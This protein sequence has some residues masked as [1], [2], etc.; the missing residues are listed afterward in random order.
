[1][2][3]ETRWD[4]FIEV[5]ALELALETRYLGKCDVLVQKRESKRVDGDIGG[6]EVS[7]LDRH[8]HSL[9]SGSR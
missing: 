2:G 1:M 9:C 3:G 8:P 7:A 4:G 6:F 5:N